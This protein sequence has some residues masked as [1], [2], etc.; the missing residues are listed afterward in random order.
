MSFSTI[1]GKT[2][3]QVLAQGYHQQRTQAQDHAREVS[4][5]LAPYLPVFTLNRLLFFFHNISTDLLSGPLLV[6]PPLSCSA[7]IGFVKV[8]SQI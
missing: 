4:S 7:G 1:A 8:S 5:Y 6:P 3:E 2:A